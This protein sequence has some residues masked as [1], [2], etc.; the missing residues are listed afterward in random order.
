[1]GFWRRGGLAQTDKLL[2]LNLLEKGAG[3]HRSKN[4]LE[5]DSLVWCNEK[6]YERP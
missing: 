2:I 5:F 1:M 4:Q 6:G 3:G